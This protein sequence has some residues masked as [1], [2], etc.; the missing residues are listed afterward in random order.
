MSR[1]SR[2][3]FTGQ[4]Q[5]TRPAAR[6]SALL[7]ALVRRARWMWLSWLEAKWAAAW[8]ELRQ[9]RA[10]RNTTR[11]DRPVLEALEPK[12]LLS[13]ELMP[14]DQAALVVVERQ[15]DV[16]A[17]QTA[18]TAVPTVHPLAVTVVVAVPT[19]TVTGPGTG[20]LVAQGGGYALQLSGTSSASSVSL[21]NPDSSP[22]A[23]TGISANSAV[24]ALNLGNANLT[25]NASFLANV[26]SLTLGQVSQATINVA[27]GTEFSLKAGTVTDTR[28]AARTANLSVNVAAW[29]ST[30]TG[31]S[32]IEAAGLKSLVISGNLGADLFLSGLASGYTLTTVQVGGTIAGGL[33]SV[34][35]RASNI[36]AGSTAAAWRV[37]L[38]STLVQ[39]VIKGDASGDLAMAGLQLLQVGGSTRGLHLLIGADLGDDAALG[40]TGANADSFKAGTLARVRIT[41]DMIDSSLLVSVDP[42]NGVL[43]DGD[44]QQLG[45]PVQRLQELIVG[46]TLR[47]STSV[48]APLFPTTVR[49]GGRDVDPAT[50]PQLAKLPPDRIA[51]VLASF[52][53][54][55][56]SDSG[57]QGDNITTAS[58]VILQGL[59]EAGALITLRASGNAS[60]LGSTTAAANGSFSVAGISLALGG[61][62]FELR[63][64]DAAGN[65][66]TASLTVV[67]EAIPDTTAPLLSAALLADTGSLAT[68]GITSN[69]AI[70]GTVTDAVGVTVLQAALDPTAGTVFTNILATL[71]AG[72]AFSLNRAL[73]DSLAGGTL[74]QGAH[75]LRL[76]AKDAAGNAST[77]DVSFTLDTQAPAVASFGLAAASDTG[78]PGDLRTTSN[79]VLL[80]GLADASTLLT[81]RAAG[82][83]AVLGST[84]AAGDGS[85][86]FVGIT[87]VLGN[88]NFELTA[89]DAAGNSTLVSLAVVREAP[90]VVDST[91][92]ALAAA[93]QTDTGS[94]ATDGI[95]SN[96]SISGTVTDAVGVTVLQA[97]LDPGVSPTFSDILASVQ[98]GGVFTLSRA[99]LDI[100]AGGTLAQGAHTLRLVAKDA[101]GNTSTVNVAFTL[102]TQAPAVASFGLAAA[103]DTGT[104]GDLRT[105]ANPVTL[106]GQAEVGAL[107]TLRA[108]GN[109]TVLGS[110]TAAADGSFSFVGITLVL[111]NNNFEL[112]AA[113][114]AGNSAQTTITVVREA[115]S[116]GDTAAPTLS[117]A[118]QNDSG[119]LNND[120]ITSDPTISGSATDDTGVTQLLAVLDP[121]ANP[122]FTNVSAQLQA[123][124]SFI[125]SRAVLDSLAGGSLADGTHTVRLMARD[126]AGNSSTAVNVIFRLD[127]QAPS[128]ASFGISSADALAGDTSKTSATIVSLSGN[129]EAGATI[130]LAAQGLSSTAG[131]NGSFQLPGV[132]LASGD[133]SITLKITDAAGNSQTISRT[134]TRVAAVQSDAVLDWISV[135]LTAIQLDVTDPPVATRVLAVQSIAVYDALAAIQGTPAFLVQRTVSGSVDA[136]AAAAQAAYRVLYALFPSQR[137]KFDAALATS[138]GAIADSAAKTA[139]IALGDSIA[140]A[141][142]DIRATDGYLNF[143]ADGGSTAIGK[144]RPT[145]P[146]YLVAQDV[147][148]TQVTPFALTSGDEFRAAAPPAL[149]SAQYA[150]ELNQVE[151]LGSATGSSRT[152]DQTQQAHFWADGGGS[153]TPPGHWDLIAAQVAAAQGNSISANA[154]LMAQLNVALADA[155]IACWDTK[156][157]YDVWRPVTAIQSAD[158]DGNAATTVNADWTPLLI[159]PPHPSY[160]SGH[161]TFSAAAAGIL[162]ATFGNNTA[163]ATTSPTLPNVVRNFTS[164]SQAADEAGLSRIYGGIHTMSDNLAGKTI[165]EHVAQAVLAKFALTQDVQAPKIVVVATPA[166]INTNLTVTG[167]VL[168]NL[169]GVASAAIRIDGGAARNL[170]LDATGHFSFTTTLAVDGTADFEH[171][172]SI[173]ATDAAGN[174]S[175]ATTGSF[176]LD[177]VGPLLTVT[178]LANGDTLSGASRLGGL[179]LGTGSGI[180]QLVYSF[181]GG[182]SRGLSFDAGS[183]GFSTALDFSSLGVG[184]HTLTVTARDAAGNSTALT[185]ALTVDALAP[186]TLVSLTPADGSGDVGVTQRPLVV[187][188]RAV[189]VNTL[190]SNTFYATGPD[191]S[192]L[193]A[194]VVP[195]DDGTYAWLFLA[196]PMPG[197]ARITVHVDGSQI[198][199][200]ADG[201]FLDADGNSVAG[202][203]AK[204]SFTTVGQLSVSGTKLVGRVVDP[205][206]DLLP[207]TFDDIR[208]GPDGVIHTADDVFLLPIAHAK[209]YILGQEAN[210]VYTDANGNFTLDNIPAGVVKVAVDGRTATNAPSGVFF[211]EMVMSAELL[212]A[213]RGR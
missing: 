16:P 197:A 158:L 154:R 32:R 138:L 146:L 40:G 132:A 83:A 28:L 155:A 72:G 175:A 85:F 199:A 164:F 98:A 5:R 59:T 176:L 133:N 44:D 136:Q 151:R 19:V 100:L 87:L 42:V 209:V 115:A 125:L 173:S 150:A 194:S 50:L 121:G 84:T 170:T 108:A 20:Q 46:G 112:T 48:I 203:A 27:A 7:L 90:V 180:T 92:P 141:V 74:G 93:L 91:P 61:N 18:A 147:Q 106:Q 101:A 57:V 99:Q 116:G 34:H 47:G 142:I 67:R 135:A 137:T 24:G 156:Y 165:G 26:T 68:D 211:P 201:A 17:A 207:M 58:P 157:T 66:T 111:G 54:A 10:R 81:L 55:P 148:W 210:F 169:S 11:V 205:G 33:W 196:K 166:A 184:S 120:G 183:G 25:G 193:A 182:S 105:S 190:N 188:S 177:T 86:S 77:V 6:P 37:N 109:A 97:A 145:G 65:T 204:V 212:V 139:G 63:V 181:D 95:T 41:G 187:F 13:A 118:L 52:G 104:A 1:Q 130:T 76:V 88:N 29:A 102:D 128:G 56:A 178:T 167:Q 162:V 30:A 163:F 172:Y 89:A 69:P 51:P 189:N 153:Y 186:F 78:T 82:N 191:G 79:P 103:S 94:L 152:A 119:L 60:V 49:V 159:T 9:W 96:P 198:R 206:P 70:T 131:G 14:L 3:R 129:A 80:Q 113:D 15:I 160:V 149:D 38:S 161:S 73:L 134:L 127:T 4:G 71:Q 202:G 117:A 39:L 21:V 31:A 122:I 64:A 43:G 185:R 192:K 179:A 8:A 22:V 168:D 174:V 140:R 110:A 126:A 143:I 35:G 200:A 62:S 124:G 45:T 144:W 195:S 107:L 171:T 36:T 114:A 2:P 23:L 53:L 123:N 208:R 213:T 75:I 12:L